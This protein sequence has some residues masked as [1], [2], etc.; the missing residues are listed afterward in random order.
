MNPILLTLG[1]S[2]DSTFLNFDLWVFRFFG[3]MQNA[4]LTIVAKMFTTFGDEAFMIPMVVVGI[5]MC[6]F[7]KTRKYGFSIIFAV[8][9]GTIVTNV[10]AK[11]MFLRV[12][13]Y[14]I[15]RF[16]LS[17][18]NGMQEL[19]HFRRVIIRSRQVIQQ[20]LPSLLLRCSFALEVT[21]RKLPTYSHSSRYAQ[22]E[23]VFI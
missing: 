18:K 11:P 10:V 4:F 14:K 13:L 22:Q 15:I 6:F 7:K 3:E 16:G 5:V 12:T 19:A 8:L 17:L 23:A 21:K 1:Q 20:V 2:I 9:I